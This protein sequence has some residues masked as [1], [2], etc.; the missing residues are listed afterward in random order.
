MIVNIPIKVEMLDEDT[1]RGF[2]ERGTITVRPSGNA[3]KPFRAR[4]TANKEGPEFDGTTEVAATSVAWAYGFQHTEETEA[5]AMADVLTEMA[6]VLLASPD[7]SDAAVVA[8]MRQVL[9]DHTGIS[10]EGV[11]DDFPHL[12]RALESDSQVELAETVQ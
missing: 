6:D 1:A 12:Q 3:E 4:L 8:A 2:I 7:R 10:I 5:E 11:N 9:S